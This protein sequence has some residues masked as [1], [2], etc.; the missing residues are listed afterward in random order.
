MKLEKCSRRDRR[1]E[2]RKHGMIVDGK[3]V[4]LLERKKWEKAQEIKKKR[5]QEEK[6]RLILDGEL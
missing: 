4:F 1:I 3:G 5:E 6:E 2:K